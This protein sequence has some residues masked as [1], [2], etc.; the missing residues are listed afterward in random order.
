ME[1]ESVNT[2]KNKKGLFSAL[3]RGPS[4]PIHAKLMVAFVL[5]IVLILV[6]ILAFY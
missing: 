4:V 3:I 6:L 2:V 1:I 5:V